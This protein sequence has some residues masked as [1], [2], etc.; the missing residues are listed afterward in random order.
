[1]TRSKSITTLV[2]LLLATWSDAQTGGRGEDHRDTVW[3]SR[4]A[5]IM[6]APVLIGETTPQVIRPNIPPVCFSVEFD[7]KITANGRVYEQCLFFNTGMGL[8]GY[9]PPSSDGLQNMLFPELPDF[10][11]TIIGMKGN[12]YQYTTSKGKGG[13]LDRWVS[14]ANSEEY[15]HR[16]TNMVFTSGTTL[17]RKGYLREYCRGNM[18]AMAYR[19]PDNPTV[20]F[21]IYGDHFPEVLHPEKFLGNFGTGYLKTSEGLMLVLETES[22]GYQSKVTDIQNTN[23]CLHTDQFLVKEVEYRSKR[24]EDIARK[25]Q[26][27]SRQAEHISGDCVPEQVAL[28]RFRQDKLRKEEEGLARSAQGNT[29]EDQAAQAGLL[30]QMDP[31]MLV[32]EDILSTELEICRIIKNRE[33]SGSASATSTAKLDCANR[34]LRAQ[35]QAEHDIQEVST[36]YPGEPGRTFAEQSKIYM[37]ISTMAACR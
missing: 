8:I 33:R 18:R 20:T 31:L 4:T 21:Y 2:F 10:N 32:R 16:Q 14:T 3:G 37:R 27:L 24:S 29:H 1:M 11:F 30:V 5:T 7:L 34:R 9:L 17:A 23:T 15:L 26:Q 6:R 19:L 12:V 35:R 28:N 25:R 22:D 36:K 13:R